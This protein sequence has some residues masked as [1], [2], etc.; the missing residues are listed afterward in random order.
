VAGAP[1]SVPIQLNLARAYVAGS[2][3]AKAGVLLDKVLAQHP[4]NPALAQE[5]ARIRSSI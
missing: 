3:E 4:D 5:V 1:D 2:E